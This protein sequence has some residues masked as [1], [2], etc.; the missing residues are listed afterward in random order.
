[1]TVI[2]RTTLPFLIVIT[3]AFTLLNSKAFGEASLISFFLFSISTGIIGLL[4]FK[5]PLFH[6]QEIKYQAPIYIWI[7]LLLVLYVF[8]HG[9]INNRISLSHLYWIACSIFLFSI[10]YWSNNTNRNEDILVKRRLIMFV[11]HGII[12]LA[13][14]KR[15]SFYCNAFLSSLLQTKIF[16]AQVRGLIPML[17]QCSWQWRFFQS[18]LYSVTLIINLSNV[19]FK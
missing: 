19:Y 1:M 4:I 12:L 3:I 11:H 5:K 15:W 8:L 10:N 2:K 16:Y 9:L 14:L 18:C 6:T 17:Q 13:F 7:F